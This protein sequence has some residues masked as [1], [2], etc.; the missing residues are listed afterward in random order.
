M[1]TGEAKAIDAAKR[2]SLDYGMRLGPYPG[3][4][5]AGYRPTCSGLAGPRSDGGHA[6]TT[7]PVIVMSATCP[8]RSRFPVGTVGRSFMCGYMWIRSLQDSFATQPRDAISLACS[9]QLGSQRLV[10]EYEHL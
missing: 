3:K 2:E 6:W 8:G 10:G 9:A 5:I 1:R 7:A 4:Q